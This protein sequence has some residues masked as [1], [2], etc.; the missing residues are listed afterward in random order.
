MDIVAEVARTVLQQRSERGDTWYLREY[1]P[2]L[3]SH[4]AANLQSE[5]GEAPNKHDLIDSL[6]VK[7]GGFERVAGARLRNLLLAGPA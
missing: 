2:S 3:A 1:F 5:L 6:T 7:A 4:I